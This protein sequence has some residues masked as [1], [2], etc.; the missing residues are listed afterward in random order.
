ML[1][2][3]TMALDGLIIPSQIPGE[4]LHP[5][6]LEEVAQTLRS[7]ASAAQVQ[8]DAAAAA[9]SGLPGV[10]ES[11][12]GPV[13]YAGLDAAGSEMDV[14][15]S[16]FTSVAQALEDFA[17]TVRP[18]KQTLADIRAEAVT[19]RNGIDGAGRVWVLAGETTRYEFDPK[20]QVG[21]NRAAVHT[22]ADVTEYLQGLGEITRLHGG[23]VQIKAHWTESSEHID[24]N[25]SLLDRVADAYAKLQNAEADCANSINRH[26]DLCVADVEKIEAWQLKQSGE[27]T[28]MLPWGH[29]VD[30]TRNCGESFWWGV[31][32]AGKEALESAGALIGYSSVVGGWSWDISWQTAGQAWLGAAEGIGSLLL[33]SFPPAMILGQLGVPVFKEA[34]DM[35]TNM[36]KGLLAWDTWAEN[37]AE[38]SGRVLVNI[39]SLFIPGAGEVAA[40]V[41]GLTAGVRAVDVLSDATRL[42]DAAEMGV[43]KLDNLVGAADNLVGDAASATTKVDDLVTVGTKVDL[44]DTADLHV[45]APHVDAPSAPHVDSPSAPHAPH[46]PEAPHAPDAPGPHRGEGV[47]DGPSAHPHEPDNGPTFPRDPNDPSLPRDPDDGTF[48]RDPNAPE[49]PRDPDAPGTPDGD[50]APP[51]DPA[52]DPGYTG[53]PDKDPAGSYAEVDGNPVWIPEQLDVVDG[54]VVRPETGASL[55]LEEY[56][57]MQRRSIHNP[58]AD[59]LTLGRYFENPTSYEQQAAA[60]GDTFFDLGDDFRAALDRGLNSKDD[61]FEFFNKPALDA[62][63]LDGKQIRFTHNPLEPDNVERFVGQEWKYLESKGFDLVEDGG[64][65]IALR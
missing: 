62:A 2:G 51:R 61:I 53:D 57:A 43:S 41:K 37:P 19:F 32:N 3:E 10:L 55:P 46:T 47:D 35:T 60:R 1:G 59:T 65:W 20:A 39:G 25:N 15:M 4:E 48:P 13:M 54:R 29:R 45:G 17:A 64:V 18:I 42:A 34:N 38:A 8:V 14:V 58:D 21:G 33:M 40:V 27:N 63:I 5:A 22:V 49:P 30:E 56:A 31:G 7:T 23:R 26:R 12:E 44:P 11:P 9:W 50:S 6:K 28:A 24:K 16:R 36:V 52:D